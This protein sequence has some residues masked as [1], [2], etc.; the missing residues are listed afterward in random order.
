MV[1]D[2]A[3]RMAASAEGLSLDEIARDMRVGRRTAERM[4]DAVLMLFPQVDEVSDPPSKRWRIRGGLSAFEQAPT[5]TEMLELSKAA[6]AL[7]VAGEPA[8]ATALEGLERKLK[9]AMRSTTLNRMAPDLEALVRAETIAVQ[10]GPRPSADEAMLTAIRA[11]VLAQQPLGF[12]YSRPGAEPRRRSVAPCGVMFGRANYLV[13]ADRETGR[14][15]TFR[16]DRMSHVA[17]QEGMAVPPADFDLGVFASQ[18][19]GIYQDEIE[20]VVLRIAPEGAAEARGWRWH[21]TQSFEDQSD[22]GVIV[23][24]RASGMRE[25]AW[26]LFT[27]GEQVQILAPERLKAVMA[28]ELAAAGRALERASA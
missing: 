1:I 8:R 16:L 21:P 12:T 25:L 11:A 5:A 18:S 24:F 27:W 7:R 14:I 15:Q 26:H 22:G 20:D 9:A 19:F 10:A 13:A 6:T 4:R 23:R 28:G 2:L 3:R 17:P